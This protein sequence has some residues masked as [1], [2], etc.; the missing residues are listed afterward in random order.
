VIE[1]AK[2]TDMERRPVTE[3]RTHEACVRHTCLEAEAFGAGTSSKLPL[4]QLPI[5]RERS[6]NANWGNAYP[7]NAS[8]VRVEAG[9]A[10]PFSVDSRA[11]LLVRNAR[12]ERCR[13]RRTRFK[14]DGLVAGATRGRSAQAT[15]RAPDTSRPIDVVL[16]DDE[17]Q[18]LEATDTAHARLGVARQSR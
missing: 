18:G 17:H 8:C 4:M 16:L 12:D 10:F 11:A 5:A 1:A 13:L 9:H 15:A 6:S 3:A 14:V 7:I 2:Q